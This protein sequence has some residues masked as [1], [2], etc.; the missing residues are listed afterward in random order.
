[1][2]LTLEECIY[3]ESKGEFPQFSPMT[4][5]KLPI[6]LKGKLYFFNPMSNSGKETIQQRHNFLFF[7]ETKPGKKVPRNYHGYLN[8]RNVVPKADPQE[9][10][11]VPSIRIHMEFP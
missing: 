3:S 6:L 7:L 9:K 11:D 2:F 10:R 5:Q 8:I 1:M 4:F